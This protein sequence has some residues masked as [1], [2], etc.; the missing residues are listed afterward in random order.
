MFLS[1]KYLERFR[2][3]RER[4]GEA[5]NEQIVAT[6]NKTSFDSLFSRTWSLKSLFVR[7]A[8]FFDPESYILMIEQVLV[9]SCMIG[10]PALA[11]R[12]WIWL[13][14][15]VGA[16]SRRLLRLFAMLIETDGDNE[17]SH[18]IYQDLVSV[19]ETGLNVL[20]YKQMVCWS[21]SMS[22]PQEAVDLLRQYLEEHNV[23]DHE[24]WLQ[25]CLL[26][27]DLGHFRKAV[28]CMEECLLY[29]PQN[30]QL[31]RMYGDLLYSCG[32][33]FEALKYYLLACR[34][35]SAKEQ[36]ENS[37]RCFMSVTVCCLDLSPQE[38]KRSNRAMDR[39]ISGIL[40]W[41]EGEIKKRLEK[42]GSCSILKIFEKKKVDW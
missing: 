22:R 1:G 33:P 5:T 7:V 2:Q 11:H 39:I 31:V 40:V 25:L 15:R 21:I 42:N 38:S 23:T 19:Q 18:Q 8:S 20:A 9:A 35:E 12:C 17:G 30:A 36:K 27:F 10:R 24:A 6:F 13:R 16:E 34:L 37:V 4:S 41:S 29:S 14:D 3:W 32:E 28:Y 26:E